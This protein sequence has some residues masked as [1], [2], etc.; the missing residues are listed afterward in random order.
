MTDLKALLANAADLA[1]EI[2]CATGTVLTILGSKLEA[3]ARARVD[4]SVVCAGCGHARVD[5]VELVGECGKRIGPERVPC[6]CREFVGSVGAQW[7]TEFE[8]QRDHLEP[9]CETC[10][11]PDCCIPTVSLSSA[12]T[13]HA[14]EPSP[15]VRSPSPASVGDEGPG[16]ASDIPQSA[17]PGQPTVRCGSCDVLPWLV[18]GDGDA[19]YTCEEHGFVALLKS[20]P[21]PPVVAGESPRGVSTDQPS[22]GEPRLDS[23]LLNVAADTLGHW[24][25]G[26]TTSLAWRSTNALITELRAR[27]SE[28]EVFEREA[29]GE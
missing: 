14:A 11:N 3:D 19:R 1:H 25:C 9:V 18:V 5:H 6:T 21:V 22:L 8:E 23:E 7:L 29:A 15:A 16:G 28:F 2:R 12:A 13:P 26:D 10:G 4:A 24:I 17:P 27:A 20:P